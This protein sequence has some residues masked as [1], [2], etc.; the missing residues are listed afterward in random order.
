MNL[1][2]ERVSKVTT[3]HLNN[4]NKKKKVIFFILEKI[5]KFPELMPPEQFLLITVASLQEE[6]FKI[7]AINFLYSCQFLA[8]HLDSSRALVTG[9]WYI[10]IYSNFSRKT[11][12]KLQEGCTQMGS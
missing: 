1:I 6:I 9:H 5:H 11:K 4:N 3:A 7:V 10:G 8:I 12:L 2:L